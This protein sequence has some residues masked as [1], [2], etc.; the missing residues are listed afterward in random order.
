MKKLILIF[1]LILVCGASAFAND[2]S[3]FRTDG[4][5][6]PAV[7]EDDFMILWNQG[8]KKYNLTNQYYW[9][10]LI[11]KPIKEPIISYCTTELINSKYKKILEQKIQKLNILLY[12]KLEYEVDGSRYY[13]MESKEF[14]LDRYSEDYFFT[15][16][17]SG[18][19]YFSHENTISFAGETFINM[20][21]D[22]NIPLP[23]L[24]N[25]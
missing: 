13:V 10:P 17:L 14:D 15:G 6:L 1:M 3:F 22:L 19:I 8:D 24:E 16:D 5:L 20:I 2:I 4:T 23:R 11:E 18:L 21:N 25:I 12:E 9:Y 7:K